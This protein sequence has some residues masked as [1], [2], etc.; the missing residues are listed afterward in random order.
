MH[1]LI[2]VALAAVSFLL[3][4]ASWA[5]LFVLLSAVFGKENYV[6]DTATYGVLPSCS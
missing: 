1:A 6:A 5:G 3:A 2:K 4:A